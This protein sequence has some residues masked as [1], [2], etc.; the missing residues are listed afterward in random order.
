MDTLA[1]LALATENASEKLLQKKSNLQKDNIF[2]RKMLKHIIGQSIYQIII[3]IIIVFDGLIF[4]LNKAIIYKE[5][6][7]YQNIQIFMINGLLMKMEKL[8]HQN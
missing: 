8:N 7:S 4:C 6:I 2:T 3:M 5:R 1:S